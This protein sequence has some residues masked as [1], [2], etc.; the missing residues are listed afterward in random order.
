VLVV[1]AGLSHEEVTSLVVTHGVA[2]ILSKHS[3]PQDLYSSI[4]EVTAGRRWIDHRL[5]GRTLRQHDRKKKLTER[6]REVLR[7]VFEGLS[8]K[9]TA[10][11]LSISESSVKAALQQL[12]AKTGVRTRGQLVRIALEQYPCEF[13]LDY[14]AA[15]DDLDQRHGDR[16]HQKNVNKPT[17]GVG[18]NQSQQP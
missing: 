9:K 13:S 11:R 2:G 8:N 18:T 3:S 10:Q 15:L 14:P 1:T 16:H 7:A 12:F 6:E 5:P 17:H 4:R